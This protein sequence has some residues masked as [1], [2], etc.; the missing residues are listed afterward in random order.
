[1][2]WTN[3]N[4]VGSLIQNV[5]ECMSVTKEGVGY[6]ISGVTGMIGILSLYHFT[7]MYLL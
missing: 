7:V 3:W 6:T 2:Q 5:Y 4:S 1:M